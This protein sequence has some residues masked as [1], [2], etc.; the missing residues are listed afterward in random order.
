MFDVPVPEVRPLHH[1][2]IKPYNATETPLTLPSIST[3]WCEDVYW[4]AI[5]A[6]GEVSNWWS[7]PHSL[8]SSVLPPVHCCQLR[9]VYSHLPL[10]TLLTM[11]TPS[12]SPPQPTWISIRRRRR[13][14][15]WRW[16]LHQYASLEKL[17]G[18]VGVHITVQYSQYS[19]YSQYRLHN[20]PRWW[21]GVLLE[22]G[23]DTL[24]VSD[25]AWAVLGHCN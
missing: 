9:L 14:S 5:T 15:W 19:Q 20:T 13:P 18:V 17:G 1:C 23:V 12:P 10:L 11:S 16:W 2:H 8:S 24:T 25:W 21:V 3:V 4:A 6:L 22:A 7:E